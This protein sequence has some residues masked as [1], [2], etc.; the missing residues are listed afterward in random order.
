MGNFDGELI[1]TD[2]IPVLLPVQNRRRTDIADTG[3]AQVGLFFVHKS[4]ENK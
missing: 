3:L 1:R 2:A 4:G